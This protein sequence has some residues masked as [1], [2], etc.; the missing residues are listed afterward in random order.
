MGQQAI[1]INGVVL[2]N[3]EEGWPADEES[4]PK[5]YHPRSRVSECRAE[6][7]NMFKSAKLTRTSWKST[8]AFRVV[9]SPVFAE[10]VSSVPTGKHPSCYHSFSNFI[11]T[12]SM[13]P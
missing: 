7:E 1:I 11:W 8:K 4:R 2:D 10:G 13:Y 6:K 12:F 5:G 9:M 3:L